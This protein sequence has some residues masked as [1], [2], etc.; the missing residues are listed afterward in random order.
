MIYIKHFSKVFILSF[1]VTS[2]GQ[3][4][5]LKPISEFDS[6]VKEGI[7]S[8][9][10]YY[11]NINDNELKL[12]LQELALNPN[13]KVGTSRQIINPT[14]DEKKVI[15]SPLNPDYEPIIPNKVLQSRLELL[16]VI[17]DFSSKLS[18]LSGTQ[19]T[20][21][22]ESAIDG[23]N[24]NLNNLI[25]HY[26]EID[27]VE[28]LNQ[29]KTGPI[30]TILKSLSTLFVNEYRWSEIK[31][32]IVKAEPQIKEILT[33]IGQDLDTLSKVSLEQARQFDL[34]SQNFYNQSSSN[35]TLEQRSELLEKIRQ[36]HSSAM[37]TENYKPSDIT[38]QMEKALTALSNAAK[39]GCAPKDLAGLKTEIDYFIDQ[40]IIL[41]DA[42][43]ELSK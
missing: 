31:K 20:Q 17:S 26:K 27:K 1:L 13:L 23:F 39:S 22:L 36:Y 2:C 14:N 32:A 5:C 8:I 3:Q 12:Y 18:E 41:K 30:L 4:A 38:T 29:Y 24:G 43:N 42:I 28:T 21:E 34:E 10:Q 16:S 19:K 9:N 6:G 15:I 7:V 37:L 11:K 33:F 35:L 40:V 25:K